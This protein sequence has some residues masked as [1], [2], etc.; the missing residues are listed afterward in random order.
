MTKQKI[1]ILLICLSTIFCIQNVNAKTYSGRFYEEGWQTS[2]V[3]VFAKEKA[4]RLDYNGWYIKS[5]A[6]K[7]IYYCIDPELQ[8]NGSKA[9][10][11][12]IVTSKSNMIKKSK[13][14][15]SNFERVNLLAYYGYKYKEGSY[16][17]NAKKWYGITQ[18]MIWR[19]IK[20]DNTWTFKKTRYGSASNSYFKKEVNEMNNLVKNHSKKSSFSNSNK[21]MKTGETIT[22]TDTNQVLPYYSITSKSNILKLNKSGNKLKITALKNGTETITL[23]KNSTISNNF[24]LFTSRTYQDIIKKGTF[25]EIT[26]NLSVTVTSNTLNL[27]KED[28]ETGSKPQNNL[29]FKNAEYEIFDNNNKKIGKI[30]TDGN[31]KGSLTIPNGTY[32]VKETKAPVGYKINNNIYKVNI[33]SKDVNLKVKDDVIK[34]K[35]KIIKEKGSKKEGYKKENDAKFEIYDSNGKLIETLK[36]DSSGNASIELVYGKYKIKQI[37]GSDGYSFIDDFELEIKENKEYFYELK[38]EKLS[39]VIFTK[40]DFSTKKPIPNTLIEVYS[41]D[42]KLVFKGRTDK[43]GKIE[44]NKLNIGKYYILEKDAPKYYL[45]NK[46]KMYFEVKS[47]GEVIKCNMENHRKKGKIKIIKKDSLDEK[48][49]KGARFEIYFNENNKKVYT[50]ITNENGEVLTDNLVVGKYC[51]RELKAP[52]GYKKENGKVCVEIKNQDEI[53]LVNMK[54]KK[55]IRIPDTFLNTDDKSLIIVIIMSVV[56]VIFIIYE[57]FKGKKKI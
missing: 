9:K 23:K 40:T 56:G 17:H 29:S 46:N 15:K 21:K 11:H 39:K 53:V 5:T 1:I 13:L 24:E 26:F 54:N 52:K 6:D 31:G 8:L 18:V 27:Q 41:N 20:K 33:N 25:P 49:L 34:G 47:N 10:S 55:N 48:L 3:G 28:G 36:T 19:T 2:K 45:L 35:L 22:L 57:T 51:I 38:N 12:T 50:G 16:N 44:I 30:K 32:N 14:S 4:G 37:E 7:N 42:N 43:N